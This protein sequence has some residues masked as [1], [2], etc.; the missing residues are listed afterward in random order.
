MI[1]VTDF[2]VKPD[3]KQPPSTP[4]NA[5]SASKAVPPASRTND[6]LQCASEMV[7]SA[8]FVAKVSFAPWYEALTPL[9]KAPK[10]RMNTAV[11]GG[12]GSWIAGMCM[13]LA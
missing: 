12:D 1:T 5:V 4:T 13:P 6:I 10:K 2:P 9:K 11:L 8:G 3:D 7:K